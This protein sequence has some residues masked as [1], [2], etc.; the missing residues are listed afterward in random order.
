MIGRSGRRVK[1][2]RGAQCAPR[3]WFESDDVYRK[4][5]PCLTPPSRGWQSA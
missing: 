5:A 4:S 1:H 3:L 2:G